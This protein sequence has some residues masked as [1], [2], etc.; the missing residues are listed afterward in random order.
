M[1]F[2]SNEKLRQVMSPDSTWFSRAVRIWADVAVVPEPD[3]PLIRS[4]PTR[5]SIFQDRNDSLL[6]TQ[7]S[8]GGVEEAGFSWCVWESRFDRR[9]INSRME[10]SPIAQISLGA[11]N[12]GK[13]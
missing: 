11:K 5:L 4:I 7:S 8:E 1:L 12:L 10:C 13:I 6:H 9:Q 2:L 3:G